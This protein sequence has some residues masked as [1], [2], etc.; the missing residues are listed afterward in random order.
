ME[1]LPGETEKPLSIQIIDDVDKPVVEGAENFILYFDDPIKTTIAMPEETTISVLDSI[2]DGIL[3]SLNFEAC[4]ETN[5]LFSYSA[6]VVQFNDTLFNVTEEEKV[7]DI[8]VIRK[9]DITK[10]STVVC[11]TKQ[12]TAISNQ[13]F[14]ERKEDAESTIHFEAGKG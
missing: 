11:Y 5:P 14:K 2:E 6:P 4:V 12:L 10:P 1:F 9:G 3:N 7:V 8:P 13:D